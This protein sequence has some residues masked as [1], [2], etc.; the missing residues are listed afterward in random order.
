MSATLSLPAVTKMGWRWSTSRC[1]GGADAKAN[2][3]RVL[4]AKAILQTL[5]ELKCSPAN[6]TR[7]T[8]PG[9]IGGG[10]KHERSVVHVTQ[11]PQAL[12][13]SFQLLRLP[14]LN[15]VEVCAHH[16]NWDL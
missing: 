13:Q 9:S 11:R 3:D 8:A 15:S 5:V 10:Q 14:L 1:L 16:H 4:L 12:S 2:D 6:A 7:R